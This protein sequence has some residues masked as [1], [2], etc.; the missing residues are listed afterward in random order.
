MSIDRFCLVDEKRI[1]NWMICTE[2][3]E[4]LQRKGGSSWGD[5]SVYVMQGGVEYLYTYIEKRPITWGKPPILLL[6]RCYVLERE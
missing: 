2:I 6:L 5:S 1:Y 4:D 3:V